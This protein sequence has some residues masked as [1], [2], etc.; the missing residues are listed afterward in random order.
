MYIGTAFKRLSQGKKGTIIII[1]IIII[2]TIIIINITIIITI[3][4]TIIII[5]IRRAIDSSVNSLHHPVCLS[6]GLHM[7]LCIVHTD[8]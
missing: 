4:I 3:N 5:T 7:V 1:I 6:N 8:I 2:I